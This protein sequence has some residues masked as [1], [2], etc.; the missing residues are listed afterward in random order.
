MAGT[1]AGGPWGSGEGSNGEIRQSQEEPL[2]WGILRTFLQGD[3]E[4]CMLWLLLIYFP[5]ILM[6]SYY[7]QLLTTI[8]LSSLAKQRADEGAFGNAGASPP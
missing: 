2:P 3:L 8:D 1:A 6:Y 4:M 5:F 7:G